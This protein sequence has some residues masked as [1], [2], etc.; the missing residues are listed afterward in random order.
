MN[1]RIANKVLT[2]A[3]NTGRLPR[4]STLQNAVRAF[5]GGARNHPRKY[6]PSGLCAAFFRM[7]YDIEQQ[8]RILRNHGFKNSFETN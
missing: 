4:G 8:H 2:R 7:G 3:M 1:L 5:P 6:L